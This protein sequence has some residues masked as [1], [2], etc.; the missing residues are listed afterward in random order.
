MK[1]TILLVDDHPVF[2]QGLR[3]ILEKEKDLKVVGE[4]GDGLEAIERFRYLAPDIVVMDINMPNIDGIEATRRILS[5]FPEARVVALSVHSSKQFV[6]DMIQAGVAG[7]IL[8]ECV[9]D[10][11]VQGLRAVLAGE[12]YLSA[13]I[14]GIVISEYKKLMSDADQPPEIPEEPILRTKLHRPPISADIIPRARLIK[15]LENG[16]QKIL[17]LISAPAG[18]GKSVLASQWL[19][20]SCLPSIWVSLDENDNDVSAFLRYVLEAIQS[21][22][23]QQVLKTK[24]LVGLAELPSLK[25][26]GRYLL[27]DLEALSERFILV[28]DD[29]HYISNT[30]VHDLLTELLTHPSPAM[31][32]VLITRR[33]PPL[34]LA[35]LQARGILTEIPS[36]LLRFNSSETKSLLERIVRRTISDK[37]A[38]VLEERMEGWV[39]GL[40]LAAMSIRSKPDQERIVDE[41][42]GPVQYVKDYLITEVLN[43]QSAPI[44]H[45]LLTTSIVDRF[46]AG[47]CDVLGGV[48]AKPSEGEIDGAA[49]IAKLQKD[50]LF[51]VA[52]DTENR[53]F[54]YHHLFHQLLQ[55]QLNQGWRPDQVAA[56]QSRANAWFAENDIIDDAKKHTLVAFRNDEHRTVPDATDDEGPS[57]H[58]R[59]SSSSSNSA[60]PPG[61]RPLQ[62]LRAG[63]RI[64]NSDFHTSQAL[65]EPLTNREI[66]VLEL[67]AQRLQNKEIADKLFVSVETIKGHLKH[68][69][70]KLGVGNRREAAEKAKKIGILSG[71]M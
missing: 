12:V 30:A 44:R 51:L 20:I 58:H 38:A 40:L 45:Y 42:Q 63:G 19:E 16:I 5:E 2:R 69:Y 60:F 43:S 39:T 25:V 57:P 36:E 32:L 55:D 15:F 62:P 23:P 71:G 49:F 59:F 10:E 46:C 47:L 21:L 1:K 37:S 14:S 53:W 9:P 22:F 4:A 41:L 3:R 35:S 52:L 48:D 26:I 70:Q 56:L 67:L 66:D 33:D 8:K 11:M 18:Y 29:Y 54:R 61:R 6:N 31:H 24:S 13:S 27:N 64:P 65:V 28:L 68:I 17:T 34:A 7:Y 50:N